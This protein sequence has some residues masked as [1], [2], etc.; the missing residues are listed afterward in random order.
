MNEKKEKKNKDEKIA[1]FFF[2]VGSMR[3]L[4]RIH[5]QTLLTD[6]LSDNISSHSYRVGIIGWFLAKEEGVDPYKVLMMC[7]FHDIAEARSGDH[8]WVHKRYV[9][10]FEDEIHEDQFG[11]M[12]HSDIKEILHEYEERQSPES[13]IAKDA[14]TL[15]QI[16]LLREYEWQGNKEAAKWL[17][18]EG[19][20][21][22]L[23]QAKRLKTET[24]K[25]LGKIIY[26]TSPSRWW[27]ELATGKNR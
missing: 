17:N 24:G 7:L 10:V 26:N 16:L 15:D 25:R 18:G 12:P 22:P 8:N 1:D 3:K 2:E 6:D 14:D 5:R 27:E 19:G 21:E 13:I 9:K 11:S 4:L 20:K 23:K